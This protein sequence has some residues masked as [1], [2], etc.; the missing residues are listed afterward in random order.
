[1][2]KKPRKRGG[3]TPT[4]RLQNTNPQW[5][6]ARRKTNRQ[7]EK[8]TICVIYF[9]FSR[10]AIRRPTLILDTVPS[11]SQFCD[12]C[13]GTKNQ[14]CVTDVS[15]IKTCAQLVPDTEALIQKQERQ[16]GYQNCARFH[17][18][19]KQTLTQFTNQCR[20]YISS[21]IA[22]S[23]STTGMFSGSV[24]LTYLLTIR[25]LEQFVS[26]LARNSRC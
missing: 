3:Y 5:C 2:I 19:H 23:R 7:N 15:L 16:P 17:T 11:L 8:E 24:S 26:D 6:S 21:R 9:H 4:R 25:T 13:S 14:K 12:H 10:A 22:P 20:Q 1:M 18:K